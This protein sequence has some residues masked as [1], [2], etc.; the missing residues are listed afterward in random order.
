MSGKNEIFLKNHSLT[1]CKIIKNVRA[2]CY[3][4]KTS[5]FFPKS[6]APGAAQLT[7]RNMTI[8]LFQKKAGRIL[9]LYCDPS[10]I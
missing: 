9:P 10:P 6:F 7:F 4:C 2:Q 5:L 3:L 1:P 8:G